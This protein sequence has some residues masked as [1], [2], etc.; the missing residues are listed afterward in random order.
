MASKQYISIIRLFEHCGIPYQGELNISR[1]KKQLTAEFGLAASG[2]IEIDTHSYNKN[3][4]FEEIEHPDVQTRI[5]YHQKLW[6][7]K[8]LLSFLEDNIFDEPGM[9][10]DMKKFQNDVVFDHFFSP[11]F[12]VSFNYIARNCLNELRLNDMAELLIFEDFLQGQDREEAFRPI[13]IFLEENIRLLKNTNKDTY[14]LIKPKIEHWVSTHWSSFLN[15]LPHEFYNSRNDLTSNLVNLTVA[16]Q[17]TNKSDCRFISTELTC[18]TQ[19]TPE[20]TDIIYSNHK[21]YTNTATTTGSGN[22]GW[23]IWV[24]IILIRILSGC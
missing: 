16:I 5:G 1:I 11:Y 20:L 12:A 22:Y 4:V 7:S 19:L 14:K 24:V 13:R 3:D 2:I 8:A 23:I 15:N 18:L 10:E 6:E 17:K 21:V 9:K